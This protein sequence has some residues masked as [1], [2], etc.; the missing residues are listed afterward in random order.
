MSYIL[1]INLINI[2]LQNWKLPQELKN[3][4]LG[5]DHAQALFFSPS[6]ILIMQL[7]FES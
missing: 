2:A 5:N 4:N 1:L 6:K 3:G 7:Y